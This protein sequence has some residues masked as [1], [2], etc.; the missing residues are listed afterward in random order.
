MAEKTVGTRIQEI[1]EV[2]G[3]SQ[4]ELARLAGMNVS[5][6]SRLESGERPATEG[7]IIKLA[8]SLRVDRATLLEG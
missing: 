7:Q 3:W 6:I 8:D 4:R 5:E 1:R 2:M